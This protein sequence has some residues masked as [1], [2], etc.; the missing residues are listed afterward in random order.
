MNYFFNS[1]FN[2][3]ESN[4]FYIFQGLLKEL[5]KNCD[6]QLKTAVIEMAAST[7]HQLQKGSKV[8][9]HL[10]AFV[11]KFMALYLQFMEDTLGSLY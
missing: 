9:F 4:F 2:F 3:V 5:I 10:E 6:L 7:E 1:I 8:I 11:A